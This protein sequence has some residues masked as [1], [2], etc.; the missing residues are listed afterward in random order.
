MH[1]SVLLLL[2]TGV[3]L[4]LGAPNKP[5]GPP[6]RKI[7][8]R[9]IAEPRS[10]TVDWNAPRHDGTFLAKRSNVHSAEYFNNPPLLSRATAQDTPPALAPKDVTPAPKGKRATAGQWENM[11]G[12]AM[13]H[14][15]P[16]SWGRGHL[17]LYYT[18]K[19][20]TCQYKSRDHYA[21]EPKQQQWSSSWENLGGELDS[22][23][24]A[25]SRKKDNVHVFC[26]GTDHQTWHRS[27]DS[28]GWGKWQA[29]GGQC[30]HEP[31]TCSWGQDHAAVYV[32]AEDGACWT[33]SYNEPKK[34]WS[35]WYNM[36]GYMASPPK[37]VTNKYEHASVYCKG[38][39]GQAW[40]KKTDPKKESGWGE[41]ET[42]GGSLDSAP[43][44]VSWEGE[45]R[46][47]VYVKGSDGA[48]WH[49]TYENV[50]TYDDKTKKTT[51]L[52]KWGAWESLGGEMKADLPPDVAVVDG[53]MEVYITGEDD[54]VY[55]K[56]WADGSWTEDWEPM[57]G[58][59]VT[60]PAVV[61]WEED[62]VE[63]YF[64]GKDGSCK[65]C[66]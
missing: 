58:S 5:Y 1:L 60:Q 24:A 45:E 35:G 22:A 4:V 34:Q 28:G 31:A 9:F 55:R 19:D 63:V 10:S 46:M 8:K 54:A 23:P 40:H 27:Y 26:K 11:A 64:A 49:K 51:T 41:W 18:G 36:G 53:G 33:R 52:P 48:C 39:D 43:A 38:D 25:C 12:S 29:M 47:D 2:T 32:A 6:R 66:Y 15:A 57:G 37:V 17:N 3:E 61:K 50:T 7:V 56:K 62:K 21:K 59:V 16:V 42:L 14:P 44:A 20:R 13:Y 30:K 65:R